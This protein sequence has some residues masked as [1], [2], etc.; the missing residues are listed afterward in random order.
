MR[1]S[2]APLAAVGHAG[3]VLKSP[4]VEKFVIKDAKGQRLREVRVGERDL[5]MKSLPPVPRSEGDGSDGEIEGWPLVEK[6]GRS[7]DEEKGG[8]RWI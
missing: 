2:H 6:A 3:L 5:K 1:I 8:G 4:V 7:G